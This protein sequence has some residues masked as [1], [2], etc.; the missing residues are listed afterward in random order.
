[1]I[2][3][4]K[5]C[6]IYCRVSSKD[7]IEGTSLETQERQCRDYALKHDWKILEIFVEL[8]ESAKTADRTEFTKAIGYCCAKKGRVDHFLVYKIDR[9][10]RKAEDHLMVRAVLSKSGTELRSVMEPIN[11]SS[12]GKLMET[13]IAGFAE[14]DNNVRAERTKVGMKQRVEEGLWIWAPP[15]GF[16]KP[17][18]GKKTN[19]APDPKTAPLIRAAFEEY[20]KGGRTY[21][22][23]ASFLERQ[24]LLTRHGKPVKLQEVQKMLRNPVYSGVISSTMG[25][26]AGAFEPIISRTLFAA[27]QQKPVSTLARIAPRSKENPSFP[28]R[29]LVRCAECGK[30]LAGSAPTGRGGKRYP[31]YHHSNQEC[32]LSRSIPKKRF[33]EIFVEHLKTLLPDAGCVKLFRAV[34]LDIW[35]TNLKRFDEEGAQI[36]ARIEKLGRD[37]QRVFEL[38]RSGVYSDQDFSE[39]KRLVGSQ[40]DVQHSLLEE[41]RARE[42]DME[43]IM[44]DALGFVTNATATWLALADNYPARIRF[45]NLLFLEKLPFDGE[46]FG[47]AKMSPILELKETSRGE[48]SL[49]V[50]PGGIEPPLPP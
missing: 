26:Y 39:Q 13:V 17:Q 35:K 29:K 27:C 8:G 33:E 25:E 37:R 45:Q 48:K 1:M 2:E 43:Q 50:A 40:L 12:T 7:Q 32:S 22:D 24:G 34:V 38:H 21:K 6:V 10:S 31:S 47:T 9:F 28:L 5:T 41:R 49:L 44:D 36:R 23:I 42:C 14:F 16:H 11:E 15:L 3:S 30:S 46:K 19:I 18:R 20:A 4:P